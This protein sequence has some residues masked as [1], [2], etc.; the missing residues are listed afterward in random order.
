MRKVYHEVQDRRT[1]QNKKW[2]FPQFH[3]LSEWLVVLQEESGEA[4]AALLEMDLGGLRD[5]LLDVAAVAI[6]MI[7]HMDRGEILAD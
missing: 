7:E 5:E 4:A 3:T 6:A 1:F 2:G